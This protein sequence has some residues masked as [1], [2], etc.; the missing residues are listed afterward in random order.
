MACSWSKQPV[1]QGGY[2]NA[3]NDSVPGGVI[4]TVPNNQAGQGQQSLPGDHVVFDDAT[5]QGIS[6]TS[7]GT[8]YGGYFQYVTLDSAASTLYLGQALYWKLTSNTQGVYCVTNVQTGNRPAFAGVVLNPTWTAGNWSWIQNLGRATMLVD[9]ASGAVSPG[10]SMSLS[11]A[12]GTSNDSVL[13]S[14]VSDATAPSLFVGISES[15]LGATPT[16]GS[17]AI[18]DIRSA[19]LRF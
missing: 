2:I 1:W 6:K 16:A 8:V 18:V 12:T 19:V 17:T 10:S 4:T 5:A 15:T 9:A 3:I 11:A 14:T 13:V 7:V